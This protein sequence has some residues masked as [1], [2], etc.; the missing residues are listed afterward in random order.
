MDRALTESE[1]QDRPF[2]SPV[3][4]RSGSRRK[5]VVIEELTVPDEKRRARGRSAGRGCQSDSSAPVSDGNSAEPATAVRR[6][7]LWE[8]EPNDLVTPMSADAAKWNDLHLREPERMRPFQMQSAAVIEGRRAR[9]CE[10]TRVGHYEY[11]EPLREVSL[12]AGYNCNVTVKV[13]GICFRVCIDTGGARS[14][15]RKEFVQQLLRSEKTREWVGE[16]CATTEK[17]ICSGI[18]KGMRSLAIEAVCDLT[19]LFQSISEDGITQD[20]DV[21]VKVN[22]AE[23]SEA[24]DA[25]LIG[26]PE[27]SA[28]DSH[29]WRDSD[30]NDWVEFRK[31]GVTLLAEKSVANQML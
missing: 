7:D 3:Q 18:C 24:A 13:G 5:R 1:R 27:L 8:F 4:S 21:A 25:M 15:I 10:P 26:Y 28:W 17:I 31:L 2:G 14:I 29:F 16:R 19:V 12:D 9:S 23:L 6:A 22:F 30:G 11:P 20:A